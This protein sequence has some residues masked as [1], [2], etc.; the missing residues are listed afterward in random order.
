MFPSLPNCLLCLSPQLEW[1][2]T[3][4]YPA[5]TNTQTHTPTPFNT[6]LPLQ[7]YKKQPSGSQIMTLSVEAVLFHWTSYLILAKQ[8]KTQ[9]NVRLQP[10]RE[11]YWAERGRKQLLMLSCSADHSRLNQTFTFLFIAAL[12]FCFTEL[13]G[14]NVKILITLTAHKPERP[15][16]TSLLHQQTDP[17]FTPEHK[18]TAVGFH[19]GV[20]DQ[21][22]VSSGRQTV[23]APH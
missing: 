3:P 4:S 15:T 6:S 21:R 14:H 2:I 23:T 8:N 17:H 1:V 19:A 7:H 10:S 5:G 12:A 22:W 13:E 20:R 18:T 9:G 16:L 11:E